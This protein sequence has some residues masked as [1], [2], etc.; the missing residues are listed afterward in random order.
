MS[1][2]IC[3][4]LQLVHLDLTS[5]Q[6]ATYHA[7]FFPRPMVILTRHHEHFL[8]SF[9]TQPFTTRKKIQA[10]DQGKSKSHRKWMS[11]KQINYNWMITI[12]SNEW[13][14]VNQSNDMHSYKMNPSIQWDDTHIMLAIQHENIACLFIFNYRKTNNDFIQWI[15][16]FQCAEVHSTGVD[17]DVIE[18]SIMWFHWC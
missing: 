17:L 11:R 10:L 8:P 6:V 4:F 18:I 9:L 16:M 5:L 2:T 13:L 12:A 7:L 14:I 15:E 1:P 3:T